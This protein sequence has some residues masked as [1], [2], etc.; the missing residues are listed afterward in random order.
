MKKLLLTL[1]LTSAALLSNAQDE[2]GNPPNEIVKYYFI[3]LIT[4]PDKPD[5]PKMQVDS[6]QREH[7]KNINQMVVDNQLMLAGP[8][9]NGGGIFIVNVK[10]IEEAEALV[11]RDPAVKSGRLLTEVRPWY[12]TK[13]AFGIEF[14]K[15]N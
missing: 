5:L 9:E 10:T 11:S 3:E 1:L 2:Q 12:T 6:I 15:D 14:K 4:N 7:M 13:G 8:F